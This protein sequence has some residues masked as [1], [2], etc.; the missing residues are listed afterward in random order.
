MEAQLLD[1]VWADPDD[2]GPRLVYAD[3]LMERGHPHGEL[4]ALQCRRAR[5]GGLP[6]A[7]EVELERQLADSLLGKV[8]E[9][10]DEVRFRRGFPHAARVINRM[11][12]LSLTHPV[13]NTFG[14]LDVNRQASFPET[15]VHV[16][17][18]LCTRSL[19]RVRGLTGASLLFLARGAAVPRLRSIEV[20]GIYHRERAEPL[21]EAI[22]ASAALPDLVQLAFD[23]EHFV[24]DAPAVALFQDTAAGRRLTELSVRCEP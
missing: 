24:A 3:W 15:T 4:I 2:D 1:S 18:F 7:R 13:W 6:S 12:R 19:R 11:D 9:F 21:L 10:V 8:G 5:G 22:A 17:R 14:D 23:P 20:G 16:I